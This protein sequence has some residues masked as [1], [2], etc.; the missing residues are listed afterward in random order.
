MGSISRTD[1]L[2]Q[3]IAGT[4]FYD[5][6]IDRLRIMKA[7]FLFQV[8]TQAPREVNYEFQP[9]DYGPF[10]PEIY[11]DLEHLLEKGYIV[12][13]TEGRSYRATQQGRQY[14]SEIN[15]P[16]KPLEALMELR[17]EVEDLSFRRLL[18]RVYTAHPASAKRSVA[19]DVL[20]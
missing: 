15:F 6:A 3:F 8:E 11:R 7:L 17:V 13:V 12:E 16:P 20:D 9:Y 1:W 19:R 4:E 10:T 14:L 2:L 5:G 18:K